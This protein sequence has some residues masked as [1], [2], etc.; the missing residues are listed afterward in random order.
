MN[1]PSLYQQ[2]WWP[3][4][5][6]TLALFVAV[7]FLLDAYTGRFEFSPSVHGEAVYRVPA[8]LWSA[9]L[10]LTHGGF[11]FGLLCEGKFG[12]VICMVSSFLGLL[13]YC[14]FFVMS[15]GAEFGGIVVYFS[16]LFFAPL[17]LF[18]LL[19]SCA[20]IWGWRDVRG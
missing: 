13:I 10:M 16:G 17:S 18:F 20:E 8:E 19:Q 11:M 12:A 2:A 5:F 15:S 3:L 14:I 4:F 9:S 7:A 1:V 6:N